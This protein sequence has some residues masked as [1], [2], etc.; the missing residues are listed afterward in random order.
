M[1]KDINNFEIKKTK[2][3]K[4]KKE[5]SSKDDYMYPIFAGLSDA[6]AN[7]WNEDGCDSWNHYIGKLYSITIN[8]SFTYI[9]LEYPTGV[10]I[11]MS[12]DGYIENSQHSQKIRMRIPEDWYIFK[13]KIDNEEIEI[14]RKTEW[15]L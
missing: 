12:E 2:T 8:G 5:I 13:I 14:K 11:N 4:E 9:S 1:G 6:Y 7:N 10:D 15:G 3:I